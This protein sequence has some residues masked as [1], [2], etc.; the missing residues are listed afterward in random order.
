MS[1]KIVSNNVFFSSID[2]T[3]LFLFNS[4][5]ALF[6][7]VIYPLTI[8]YASGSEGSLGGITETERTFFKSKF[9]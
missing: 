2:F 4:L 3:S 8:I 1:K 7:N 5:Y 9:S 6:K